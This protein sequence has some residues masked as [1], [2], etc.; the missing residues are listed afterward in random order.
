[1]MIRMAKDYDYT[2]IVTINEE[3]L[4]KIHK[5]LEDAKQLSGRNIKQTVNTAIILICQI[6]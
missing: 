6:Y 5:P 3:I 2:Q 4:Q 1:M